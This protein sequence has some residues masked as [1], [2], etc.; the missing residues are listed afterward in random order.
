MNQ[1]LRRLAALAG[2]NGR[3]KVDLNPPVT[4]PSAALQEHFLTTLIEAKDRL[5]RHDLKAGRV[6]LPSGD[7][8]RLKLGQTLLALHLLRSA[9]ADVGTHREQLT[10]GDMW[11]R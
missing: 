5:N 1:V 3:M 10:G 7:E 9:A 4:I 2:L 6:D 8:E 11:N